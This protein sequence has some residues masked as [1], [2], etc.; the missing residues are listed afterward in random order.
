METD[1]DGK[2]WLR[3][4]LSVQ[5]SVNNTFVKIGQ[6]G[7]TGEDKVARV[8]DANDKFVVYEDGTMRATGAYFEGEGI[9][10]FEGE[11]HATSGTFTGEIHAS[12]G[13]IGGLDIESIIPEYEVRITTT[14]GTSFKNG[15]GTKTLTA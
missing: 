12:S 14:K 13:T 11:I 4:E 7:K 1:S 15:Q 8:I 5:T 2:L 3:K 6:L 9:G 10:K